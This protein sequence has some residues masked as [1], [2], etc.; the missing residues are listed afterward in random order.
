MGV[1]EFE[2]EVKTYFN[3]NGTQFGIIN[4]VPL[5]QWNMNQCWVHTAH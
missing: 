2:V 3:T 1:V 4:Q 5:S